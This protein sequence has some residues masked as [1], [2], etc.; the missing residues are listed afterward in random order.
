MVFDATFNNI[1]V[2]SCAVSFIRG[3]NRMTRRKPPTCHKSLTNF[4]HNVVHLTLL[5][6]ELITVTILRQMRQMSHTEIDNFFFYTYT[7]IL[8]KN[9]II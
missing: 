6:I 8:F 9:Y 5:E 4:I 1:S 2:I 7:K 3:G